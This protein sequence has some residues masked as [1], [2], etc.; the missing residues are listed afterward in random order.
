M[1]KV[2]LDAGHGGRDPGAMGNNLKEKD[3]ALSYTLEIGK[4][5][6]KHGIDVYYSRTDDEFVELIDRAN[7]ANGLGVDM[8][9]SLHL[10]SFS[11]P[12]AQGFEIYHFPGSS[13]GYALSKDIHFEILTNNLLTKDRGVKSGNFAVLRRTRMKSCLIELGFISNIEDVTLLG[14]RQSEVVEAIS[15]GIL[16]NLGIKYI[17]E[18]LEMLDKPSN[19]AKNW[20]K[21][22]EEGI[23]DGTRPKDNVTREEVVEML[24][25]MK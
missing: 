10:N 6:D 19:W 9:V 16:K 23:V 20:D 12:E 11:K 13:E 18:E 3:R 14:D 25:R 8:F 21:A 1:V 17:K 2:F 5:L 7:R 4:E 22:T 15:K 24:Y